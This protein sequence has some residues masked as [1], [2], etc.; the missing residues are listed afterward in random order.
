MWIVF[1]KNV[2][3][4]VVFINPNFRLRLMFSKYCHIIKLMLKMFTH[5][6]IGK[7]W[8]GFELSVAYLHHHKAMSTMYNKFIVRARPFD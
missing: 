5:L 2:E 8:L 7:K 3:M 6:V 1:G 4:I